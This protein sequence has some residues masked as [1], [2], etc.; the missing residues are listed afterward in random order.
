MPSGDDVALELDRTEKR[1]RDYERIIQ[2][3]KRERYQRI[4]W[5]TREKAAPR[6][7]E[8]CERDAWA[9]QRIEVGV[10]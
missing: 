9:K 2:A 10:W 1:A 6:L 4:W 3:Y 7:R 8:L 5:F